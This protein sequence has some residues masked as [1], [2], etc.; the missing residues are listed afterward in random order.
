MQ[1]FMHNDAP[2]HRGE[3]A[4]KLLQDHRIKVLDWPGD[5]LDL[6]PIE[7]AWS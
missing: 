3:K 2:C 6:N 4:Q 7:N 5:S 1:V